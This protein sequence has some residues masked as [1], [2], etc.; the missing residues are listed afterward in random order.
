MSANPAFENTELNVLETGHLTD[1]SITEN[2]GTREK[3][4]D[5]IQ[6]IYDALDDFLSKHHRVV[7][8]FLMT[9]GNLIVL[10]Y[11]I[12]ATIYWK[13]NYNYFDWCHGY[14]LLLLILA[15]VYGSLFYHYALKPFF[16]KI[17]VYCHRPYISNIT[18]NF[19][20]IK[21][22]NI[23]GQTIIYTCIFTAIIVF[24][25]IDTVNSRERLMS[26]IGIIVLISLGWI[27]SKHPSHIKWK[28]V[29]NA[30]IVQI[31]F[32]LFT[33]RW[34]VGRSIFQCIADKVESFLNFA[35]IGASFIFSDKLI[36]DGI[37]AFTVLPVLFYFN[38]IIQMLYYLGIMQWIIFNLGKF[39]QKLMGTSICESVV[40]AGNIFIGMTETPL[41]IK[42]YL[43][44]LTTSELHTLMS[45]GFGTVS[46]TVFAA[47]INFGANPAHLITATLMAAPATLCYAKLFYPETEKIIITS[48]NVK[49]E[50]SKDTGLI[51]AASKG[52]TAAI[53]L[54]LNIIANIVGFVS[55]IA[56]VNSLLSWIGSLIGYEKLSF[57]LILSKVFI[58]ISWVMGVPWDH[59]E[60]VATLIGLKTTVNEFVA[61]KELGKYKKEG[62]IFGRIEAIATFAICGF[63]NPGSVGITISILTSLAP[64]KKEI[65]SNIVMRAFISGCVITFLTASVAGMLVPDDY[66]HISAFVSNRTLS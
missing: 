34:S 65:I 48:D 50:K 35:K 56:L 44:K 59:C 21:Y 15:I 66:E 27:F 16:G 53:P 12:F 17:F 20:K 31:I 10:I 38:F 9:L 42:P 32:G 1:E 47:Y 3:S 45:S 63:A 36:A 60:D 40:C 26:G 18:N 19:R 46:G 25:I 5:C 57:E 2:K 52:A 51:D 8:F 33:I 61:Y 24:L 30:L 39:L 41:M 22:G 54:V 55:F 29:L 43:N 4:S 58:P 28:L 11:F 49:L 13:N 7:H 62:R 64:D 14:G 6:S 37:F 23:I